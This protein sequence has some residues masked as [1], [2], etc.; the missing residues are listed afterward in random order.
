MYGLLRSISAPR[1]PKELKFTE[2]VDSL[3]Q[4]LDPKPIVIAERFKFHKAEQEDSESIRQFLA[5]LQK[6]AETCEF[7]GYREEAI[8]DRFVCGLRVRSIQRKLLA[9]ATLTLQTA[10]E[11]ACAAELTERETSVLH[12]DA[13]VKSGSGRNVSRMFQMWKTQPF[14]GKLLLSQRAMSQMPEVRPHCSKVSREAITKET[15]S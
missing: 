14:F 2:I 13:L 15:N 1:K 3:S 9:E 8:R 12:G 5:K 6:L 10:V 11:K 7:G 4:H